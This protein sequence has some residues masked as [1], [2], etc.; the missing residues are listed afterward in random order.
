[1]EPSTICL[2]VILISMILFMIPKIPILFTSIFATMALYFTGVSTANEAFSGFNS[3]ATWFLIGMS[4]VSAAFFTTGLSDVVG[5][6]LFRLTGGN[7]KRVSVTLYIIG[8]ILSVFMSCLTVMIMFA[9]MIDA[10]VAKSGGRLNRKMSYMPVALGSLFGGN[11]SLSGSTNLLTTS[12]M[13]EEVTGKTFEFFTPLPLGIVAIVVGLLFYLTVGTKFQMKVF[14]SDAPV[15]LQPKE[16]ESVHETNRVEL[17]LQMKIAAVVMAVT[18]ILLIWNKWSMGAVCFAAAAVLLATKTITAEEMIQA[19]PWNVVIYVAALIGFASG[20]N[21]SGAGEVI[22]EWMIDF[23]ESVGLG[24]FGLCVLHMLLCQLVSNF[25]SNN[26]AVVILVPIGM[27]VATLTGVDPFA[28][29]LASVI[30]INTAFITPISSPMM[31]VTLQ[32]GFRFSDYVKGNLI[33]NVCTFLATILALYMF[34]Y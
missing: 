32:A 10:M 23:G 26:A 27:S 24:A 34:Y 33:L 21:V 20:I 31:S 29:G 7:Q 17:T 2:L 5:T 15:W 12:A 18:I 25:M 1:M 4:L 9:P 16:M 30:S 13:I 14:G 6:F 11:I 3:S 28:L 19:V 8:A 22:G